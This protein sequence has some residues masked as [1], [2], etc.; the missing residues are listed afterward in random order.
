MKK[1]YNLVIIGAG[2]AG[3][4]A[5]YS[6]IRAGLENV[7]LIDRKKQENI[8]Q[9]VC[10]D[11]IG[12]KHI[13]FLNDIAIKIPDNAIAEYPTKARFVAPDEKKEFLVDIEGELAI[14]NRKVFG[15]ALLKA[16]LREGVIFSEKTTFKDLTRKN[17]QVLLNCQTSRKKQQKITAKIVIDASGFHS[18][19]REK[20]NLF[21]P[22]AHIKDSEQY[23]CYR[24]IG[25]IKNS[26]ERYKKTVI[27]HFKNAVTKGG[28]M[29]YFHKGKNKYNLGT[30]VPNNIAG[31][32]NPREIFKQYM[33]PRFE[34][35]EAIH[36]GGGFVPTRHPLPSVVTDNIMLVGDAGAIVNPLHG[37]G[38]GASLFSGY[39]A[40][41][42]AA[43]LIP[44]EE[45]GEGS[46]W[47]YNLQLWKRYGGRYAILDLLRILLQAIT[48]QE[49][50]NVLDKELL[51]LNQIFYARD[52]SKIKSLGKKLAQKWMTL[53]KNRLQI[54]PKYL[55]KI[56]EAI[57]T[58][59]KSPDTMNEWL[60]N[61]ETIYEK[62]IQ[63]MASFEKQE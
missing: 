53:E 35:Y 63:E 57:K 16:A 61:Y 10:G 2:T 9:K 55:M 26:M 31:K 46:L 3:C 21:G 44:T 32:H 18:K 25:S 4:L 52:Y 12:T 62:C 19:I 48:D 60:R 50:N 6:A 11:G 42:L 33:K 45:F 13:K 23:Y 54:L 28:Y 36:Q 20:R 29:W 39:K 22:W 43:E 47:K 59:P 30:G 14:I 58:Y 1:K 34:N 27:F 8:G 37:G 40:G 38:L 7:L 5:A 41:L 15:Q 56:Q 24:E 49:L 51:P 17:N